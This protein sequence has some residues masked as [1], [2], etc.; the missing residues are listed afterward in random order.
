M[1]DKK[2]HPVVEL[3]LARMKSHPEEFEDEY[4]LSELRPTRST[5]RWEPALNAIGHHGSEQDVK[6]INEAQGAIRMDQIHAWAMDELCNGEERRRK[7]DL[8]N[9]LATQKLFAQQ[10][11]AQQQ[12]QGYRASQALT[13]AS[14]LGVPY[15]YNTVSDTYSLL[16][17]QQVTRAEAEDNGLFGSV[18]KA[19]GL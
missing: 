6:A 14:T 12:L 2:L 16:G 3:L 17:G 18:K 9:T 1:E 5:G 19:L 4:L 13:S 7:H 15:T 11:L 8:D 10:A